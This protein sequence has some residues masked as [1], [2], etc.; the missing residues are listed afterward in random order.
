[1]KL[2]Q[3]IH[4]R[5]PF[6]LTD[7]PNRRYVMYGT[8]GETAW[9]GQPVG[10]D[11]YITEDLIH[12][13]G[14]V[15]VFRPNVD[16][17][18]DQHYWA[19]EV[20]EYKGAYYMLASF[21]AE[22]ACRATQILRSD[23]PLG[24]FLPYGPGP[25][26]PA[27]WECLDGTLHIDGQGQPWVIFC[28]E[29]LEVGD[30]QV[31]AAPLLPDLTARADEPVLLFRASE[32]AWSRAMHDGK[33]YV[34]DGPF[35]YSG[36]QGE[37]NMLWSSQGEKGYAMGKAISASGEIIGPWRQQERPLFAEN[38]GH[39]MIFTALDGQRYISLH[40]PNDH[41]FERQVFIPLPKDA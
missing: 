20:H 40:T 21:K 22:H 12:W 9:T 38:G 16:F 14:P 29:W 33:D 35:L 25:I 34:T 4:I 15:A 32:A 26:T 19:P 36:A 13:E 3:D 1:M 8:I 6:I 41:P 37:L 10:F 23:S 2:L 31:W 7:S 5:D 11:A 30:G 28:R 17:W 24:P 18:S 39:G 27:D